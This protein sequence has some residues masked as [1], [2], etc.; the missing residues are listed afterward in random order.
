MCRRLGVLAC[1]AWAECFLRFD[2]EGIFFYRVLR[3]V[4]YTGWL[5]KV[6]LDLQA[7]FLFTLDIL[8]LLLR[9]MCRAYAFH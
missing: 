2:Q 1:A 3:E 7:P 5:L 6:M 4:N 8:L 9:R